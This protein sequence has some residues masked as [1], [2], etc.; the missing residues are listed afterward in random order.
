MHLGQQF[1]T[2]I[3]NNGGKQFTIFGQGLGSQIVP[4]V[5][6]VVGAV[7]GPVVGPAI[8]PVVGPV[9]DPVVDPVVGPVVVGFATRIVI[10]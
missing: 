9:V 4:V 5:R 3:L 1:F 6:P 7:L 2:T 8:G 10:Y